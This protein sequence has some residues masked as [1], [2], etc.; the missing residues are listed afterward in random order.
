MRGGALSAIA[1]PGP[2]KTTWPAKPKGFSIVRNA[3]AGAFQQPEFHR[4]NQSDILN[5]SEK[6]NKAMS[7]GCRQDR[8]E[9]RDCLCLWQRPNGLGPLA[10]DSMNPA[11]GECPL[12]HEIRKSLRIAIYLP[13]PFSAVDKNQGNGRW[14]WPRGPDALIADNKPDYAVKGRS[15]PA[16]PPRQTGVA[17]RPG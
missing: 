4:K 3:L 15:A 10:K 2:V 16:F 13:S 1:A 7:T 14:R 6:T 5:L 9:P 11:D 12:A 8:S 17:D